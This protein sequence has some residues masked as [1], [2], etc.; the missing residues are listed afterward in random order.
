[1]HEN[2]TKTLIQNDWPTTCITDVIIGDSKKCDSSP[3]QDEVYLCELACGGSQRNYRK[4][5]FDLWLERRGEL[6]SAEG[7]EGKEY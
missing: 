4:V 5:T 7:Q 1:M 2:K 6:S 3:N